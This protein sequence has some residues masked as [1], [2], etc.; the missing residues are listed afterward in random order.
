LAACLWAG[1]FIFLA[2][3]AHAALQ[4]VLDGNAS[5]DV[6]VYS[7][8]PSINHAL[9]ASGGAGQSD[10]DDPARKTAGAAGQSKRYLGT[11]LNDSKHEIIAEFIGEDEKHFLI[12]PKELEDIGLVCAVAA[13]T[14]DG[15]IDISALPHVV[16][17]YDGNKQTIHFRTSDH[18]AL[19]PMEINL[20]NRRHL[21][22]R[23]ALL[24]SRVE[25]DRLV[26]QSHLGALVNYM[27]YASSGSGNFSDS[28]Q[29][30]GLS[31]QIDGR[32]FGSWGTF[33]SNQIVRFGSG[34][35][36]DTVRL[37]SY[38]SYW[39][40]ELLTSYSAGDFITRSLPWTR[41]V[42]MGGVAW[43][44][45]FN[46]SSNLVTMPLPSFSG[47]AAVP[48]SV[49]VYVNNLRRNSSELPVGPYRIADLPVVNGANEARI[50]VKDALGRE[51]VTEIPF[52]ASIDMLARGLV[53]FS[54]E[55]GFMRYGYA[56]RSN[57]YGRD[58]AASGIFRYGVADFLT[59]EGHG[60]YTPGFY[61]GG[62]GAVFN[63]GSIGVMSV[64]GAV[65]H[66]QGK[67]G[68]QVAAGFEMEYAGLR[69]NMRSQQVFNHYDDLA[70]A[71]A[72]NP[73]YDILDITEDNN[74]YHS[75]S[76]RPV[77]SLEQ[78][79]VG[80]PLKFDPATL[81]VSFTQ[82]E[83]YNVRKV[84]LLGF[85]LS[86][87]FSNRVFGY[88]T[89]YKDM[90]QS[91][92]YG[93]FAGLSIGLNNNMQFSSGVIQD[94]NGT[95]FQT[96][97]YKSGTQEIGSAGWRLRDIEG[98]RTQRSAYGSY[99]ARAAHVSGFVEQGHDNYR[100]TAEVEG[101]VVMAGG[102]VFAANRIDDSFAVVDAGA[103]G[104][105]VSRE[106]RPYGRTGK[107]G[108]LVISDLISYQ[109]ANLSIDPSS[110]PF[111]SVAA[112]TRVNVMPA[113]RTGVVA[114]FDIGQTDSSA[115]IAVLDENDKPIELGS[116]V[117]TRSGEEKTTI[118]YD[119][120]TLLSLDGVRLPSL[121]IIRRAH[122][123]LCQIIISSSVSLG[124]LDGVTPVQCTPLKENTHAE[125]A[126]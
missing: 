7:E 30:Q 94:W 12:T 111:S 13:L 100:I 103:P 104:I 87:S 3:F 1:I 15:L 28:W 33:S 34:G 35:Y 114:R 70:S 109:P 113:Y 85:S 57:D 38:W 24:E 106:N 115:L 40:S 26:A 112:S 46:I 92:N 119:G 107:N 77:K 55:G 83:Y 41:S 63:V 76:N 69:F 50:V 19:I 56:T 52:Y 86:R 44:R 84:Q 5:Q 98:A 10:P 18:A 74:N 39:D 121:F 42:R 96:E 48:S 78:I 59:L 23:Q 20:L 73:D 47:S 37:D 82:S 125:V 25:D 97:L 81:N 117:Q 51:T 27:L 45:N 53:D 49:D 14:R 89:A 116:I 95:S 11:Y 2:E 8:I 123:G 67:N 75:G 105:S 29:F 91:G 22:G 32:V 99:R 21:T 17:D 66:Y 108:K 120:Q 61:N 65:S 88:A 90:K 126:L 93:I 124:I 68:Q 16:F 43:R 79:S 31:G 118:G 60:E 122:G 71:T 58:F 80:I 54:L 101:A 9:P 72:R 4:T 102:S 62:L 64:S 6:Q 36:Q 110:L